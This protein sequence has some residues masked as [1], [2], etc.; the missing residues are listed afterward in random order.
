MWRWLSVARLGLRPLLISSHISMQSLNPMSNCYVRPISHNLESYF[1]VTNKYCNVLDWHSLLRDRIMEFIRIIH[2]ICKAEIYVSHGK[3]CIVWPS[4]LL[5]WAIN[6]LTIQAVGGRSHMSLD[7][8]WI[9]YPCSFCLAV[10]KFT[11]KNQVFE[12]RGSTKIQ[13]HS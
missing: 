4:L 3:I 2:S 5:T 10:D 13:F 7:T 6:P 11:E 1:I 8:W 9:S 12:G